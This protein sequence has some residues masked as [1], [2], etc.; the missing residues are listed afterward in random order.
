MVALVLR[1]N[2]VFLEDLAD[3]LS[4][5]PVVTADRLE[6]LSSNIAGR[7]YLLSAVL[8]LKRERAGFL[9][10]INEAQ[11][12]RFWMK[13]F[14][15]RAN[16]IGSAADAFEAGTKM[17][18]L[19]VEVSLSGEVARRLSKDVEAQPKIYFKLPNAAFGAAA[20]SDL[21]RT[22]AVRAAHEIDIFHAASPARSAAT[23]RHVSK[24][25]LSP[26]TAEMRPA[27]CA[28]GKRLPLA[29]LLIAAWV[30]LAFSARSLWLRA[31][32]LS[33]YAARAFA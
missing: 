7:K 9:H 25:T 21:D 5:D 14:R 32:G 31:P 16:D 28:S 13:P 23:W 15:R 33:K 24:G 12:L 18:E 30:H 1:R 19:N 3:A 20:T 29:Y 8:W 4:R 17:G 26:V 2:A 10:D 11:K 22:G 27:V 6:R